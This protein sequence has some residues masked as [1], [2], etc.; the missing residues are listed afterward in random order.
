MPRPHAS[1]VVAGIP[2]W[3]PEP[4]CFTLLRH[5]LRVLIPSI[6]LCLSYSSRRHSLWPSCLLT[7]AWAQLD[8]RICFIFLHLG[9]DP[10]LLITPDSSVLCF[11]VVFMVTPWVQASSRV[12]KR[13]FSSPTSPS[14]ATPHQ[15]SVFLMGR[16][17]GLIRAAYLGCYVKSWLPW[18]RNFS[19]MYD[20][21]QF[22]MC[23]REAMQGFPV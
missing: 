11:W 10:W 12:G 2:R 9:A 7:N 21:W 18:R 1:P 5:I 23:L 4:F 14:W 15:I 19:V 3:D 17:W 6:S 8:A 20:L 22:C 13:I 16:I